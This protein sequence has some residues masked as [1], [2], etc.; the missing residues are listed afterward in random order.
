MTLM[1][2]EYGNERPKAHLSQWFLC[3]G[4]MG[5]LVAIVVDV[6]IS[7]NRIPTT[8]ALSLWPGSIVGLID[9]TSLGSKILVGVA[10][11]G[12][13]ILLYAVIGLA[14]GWCINRLRGLVARSSAT[15]D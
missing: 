2:G 12:S 14:M 7:Y 11:F 13:N 8:L 6:L 1:D 4:L 9:P 10:T 15:A 5:F 3:A